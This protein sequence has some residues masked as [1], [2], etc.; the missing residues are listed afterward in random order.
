MAIFSCFTQAYPQG[1]SCR[2]RPFDKEMQ[3]NNKYDEMDCPQNG[4]RG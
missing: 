2:N 1:M 3:M 4:F